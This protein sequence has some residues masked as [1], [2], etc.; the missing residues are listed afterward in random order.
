[1][2]TVSQNYKDNIIKQGREI[3]SKITY[4]IGGVETELGGDKLNSVN[5]HFEGDILKSVMKGLD[6]DS[7]V[8]IPVGTVLTYQFGVYTGQ[9]YEYI[10][11]GEYVVKTSE[12]QENERS[13][14]ITCYDKMLFAMKPYDN[15][16]I[17]YPIS[18]RDY[19]NALC[20]KIGLVFANANSIFPNYN[21]I[22]PNEL[23]LD[24][25]GKS[26][27]YTYRDVLDE[28]AQVTAST[29]C[30]NNQE[31]VELRYITN[32]N[33]TINESFLKDTNVNFGKKY[34][35]I[36]SVVLSRAGGTDNIYLRDE[37][38]IT[39]NGLC[40]IKIQDN[41][42]L[43]GNDR[44][45]YLPA[46]LDKVD[47]LQYYLNN[48]SST[49][50][51]YYDICD[52][53][54]VKI[55]DKTYSCV[56]FNNDTRISQGIE[57]D[58]STEEPKKSETDY[59]KSSKTDRMINQTNL[60][61]DKQN[62]KISGVISTTEAQNQKI[63]RVEQDIS[64]I[65][66]SISDIADI[67]ITAESTYATIN[68]DNVNESEP[69]AIKVHPTSQNISL[70]YPRNNLYPSNNLYSTTRTIRFTNTTTNETIDYELPTDLL[71]LNSNTYDEFIL[72]Y[73]AGICKVIKRLKY[74][75]NGGVETQT[76]E[77][78]NYPY[79]T[80]P[81][82]MGNYTI[83]LL[84]YD[85]G[86]IM[87]RAMASNIY[88]NQFA[89]KVEMHSAID[90]TASEINLEVS[91]KVGKNEV[92]SRINQTA[93]AVTIDASKININGTINAINNN[94][95]TTIDGDKI[96]TGSITADQIK[97]ETITADKVSSDIITTNNFS[98]QN[99]D[100]GKITSGY[101]NV[102]RIRAGSITSTEV[103]SDVITTN[104]FSA[105]NINADNIKAG[106]LSAGAIS[107][108]GTYL[109]PYSSTIAGMSVTG[110][111]IQ[112]SRM[113]MDTSNGILSVFNSSGGSMI[114]S[115]AARLSAT[116]GIGISSNSNGQVSAPSQNVDIKACSGAKVYLGCMGNSNGTDERAG[117]EVANRTLYL[118]SDGVIYANGVA[119]GGSS[120]RATKTNIKD[121]SQE[122][123]DELYE[124]IKNIPLKEYDYKKQYGKPNNYGF[125]IED[126]EDTK[127]D[128]L[129]HINHDN[130]NKDI[131]NYCS[132]DLVRLELVI[133][134]EL[135]KKIDKLEKEI[136]K[137]GKN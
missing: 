99:I 87:V 23:Y 89:T 38:S 30:L 68:L 128:T 45:D 2:K 44:S 118:R 93:E 3:D 72:D 57:E 108:K 11:Y 98:A 50:I 14:L 63:S 116:A 69:I 121:L 111:T 130:K 13:Y 49:G 7:N 86:Y 26:L 92:I 29:I 41:Q 134:Q 136:D 123:K 117:V 100:A 124:L 6:I 129:L 51:T 75:A 65:K 35:P 70:L 137:Y 127:L 12:K 10:N 97:G 46:I 71:Y 43:N 101:I 53:Y 48:F 91:K 110:G 105:Q 78:L 1:M 109:S 59:S 22:I 42:I 96:T 81:L 106:T 62:Q 20:I 102:D 36:N 74:N 18:I 77:T 84:G 88:T 83:S 112:N 40:E 90:Q 61:V 95:T 28:L 52:R 126:I 64:E 19:I 122:K 125:I 55:G 17:T 113:K 131:K 31:Q 120:S 16:G 8:Y 135:M 82:T 80:I 37:E 56:M 107:L 60:I 67:T 54:N 25:N 133:I 4:T 32:T 33:D 132:E 85:N 73:E 76:E 103:A 94:T 24:S 104:N 47:G 39:A 114:L 79:P 9:E 27:D 34:G 119:I 58:I 66:Q 21:K 115:N 15:L 5:P